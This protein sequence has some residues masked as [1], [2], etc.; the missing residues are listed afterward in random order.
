VEADRIIAAVTAAIR[1]AQPARLVPVADAAV[2]LGVSQCTVR[3]GIADGS[4]PH[5][6]VRGRV[7]VDLSP[8]ASEGDLFMQSDSLSGAARR[9]PHADAAGST[10]PRRRGGPQS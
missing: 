6:R 2:E 8:P 1:Q 3:R 5:R 7:L 4:I 10:P 9:G